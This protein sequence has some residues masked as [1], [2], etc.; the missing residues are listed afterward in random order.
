R[1][2]RIPLG[3]RLRYGQRNTI[4]VQ[5]SGEAGSILLA[6]GEAELAEGLR[7]LR[8]RDHK[9][10][11]RTLAEMEPEGYFPYWLSG[12][13]GFWTVVGVDGDFKESLF[14]QDGTI[15]PYKCFSI[16]PFI[17]RDG[18]LFTRA[19]AQIDQSL[20]K[21]FLPL[22]AVTWTLEGL[23]LRVSAFGA[24]PAGA[25]TTYVRY[26]LG[27]TETNPVA[28]KLYLA[29]RPF[30]V[31]PPWQWGG[32]T[33]IHHAEHTSD[34]IR[35]N[36]Y[37]LVPLTPPTAFGAAA[38]DAGDITRFLEQGRLP[39]S[40][41]VHDDQGLASAALE[42]DFELGPGETRAMDLALPLYET[43]V[44]AGTFAELAPEVAGAWHDRLGP[45]RFS[46]PDRE[47]SD[48]ARASLA[49]LL[50]NRD[51]PAIQ[52]GSRGY[53]A[54]WMRDGAVSSAT[55]L[56]L[57]FT[58]EVRAFID[59]YATHLFEDGRV[60][61][62]VIIGRNEVNPVH[63]YDSQGQFVY[64][65]REYFR[66]TNDRAFLEQHWPAI[67]KALWYLARIRKG[68]AIEARRNDPDQRRY[69]GILPKCVSHEGYYPEPGNHSY[70]DNFWALRGW[71]DGRAIALELGR[72]KAAKWMAGEEAKLRRALAASLRATMEHYKIEYVPGCAELG[73]FDPSS[74]SIALTIC[75]EP[76]IVPR[77]AWTNTFERYWGDVERRFLPGWRDSF[78]PYE[79]RIVL[80]LMGLGQKD[81]ALRLLD[82]LM[83]CR[84][85]VGWRQWPEAVYEPADQGGFIGDMP[86]TWV[87][88]GYLS[89][90]RS[91]FIEEREGDGVIVLAA[92]VPAAWVESGQEVGIRNAP[93]Y[94]GVVNCRMK[95]QDG[96]L[97]VRLSGTARPPGGFIFKSPLPQET[98]ECRIDT[99]PAELI[100]VR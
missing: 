69:Y 55:L 18:R 59:W 61:A 77:E 58:N 66:F 27:N 71:K 97:H 49:Y 22:P 68:E 84:R 54:A 91:L 52:P 1:K 57:G 43:S 13:Q 38:G 90:L 86:H 70:W 21:G 8:K 34:W 42:Y 67:V 20:E 72:A 83:S 100:I 53:E 76:D 74:S 62:I 51:G 41:S 63:E 44:V 92:G 11:Y 94:W 47:Y 56:R 99:I 50:L 64:A 80:A 16:S 30:E 93:T 88:S 45:V 37:R 14:C 79:L 33:R 6:G 48:T 40:V 73:D 4:V 19:D 89:T 85:P 2:A 5:G 75:D 32:F 15:E 46:V 17:Y 87:A 9:A 35:V 60:P 10:Y 39:E 23:T 31:N 95:L 7:Q 24:G 81:R 82:Y 96:R 29:A 65:C 12:R 98:G 36:E 78:S 25:S 28:G 3:S 26:E